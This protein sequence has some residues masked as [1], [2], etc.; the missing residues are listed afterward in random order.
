MDWFHEMLSVSTIR[1][2]QGV[3]T[4]KLCGNVA[5]AKIISATRLGAGHFRTKWPGI[6]QIKSGCT[7]TQSHTPLLLSQP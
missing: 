2:M 5:I 7:R 4:T 3:R 1:P 6:S